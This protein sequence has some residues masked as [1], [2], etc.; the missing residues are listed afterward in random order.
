MK[1]VA[2]NAEFYEKE[3]LARANQKKH[4]I[5]LISNQLGPDTAIYA[6]GKEAVIILAGYQPS[7]EVMTQLNNMGIKY[8]AT[9]AETPDHV[10]SLQKPMYNL[11]L[12]KISATDRND[13]N[14]LQSVA[15]EIIDLLDRWQ[16]KKCVGKACICARKCR[17]IKES[18]S[19]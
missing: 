6:E 2:Y 12:A 4:D 10:L 14:R 11:K 17:S 18:V 15:N 13:P 7:H 19:V 5:T 9:R 3:Y 1:V 8:L 16:G